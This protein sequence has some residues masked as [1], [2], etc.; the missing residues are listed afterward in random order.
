V[1]ATPEDVVERPTLARAEKAR[2]LI[3]AILKY[4]TLLVEQILVAFP[5][6]TVPAVEKITL[7]TTEEM[8]PYLREPGSPGW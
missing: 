6:G 2:R 4:L 8:T 1:A 5:A 3:A 7:R